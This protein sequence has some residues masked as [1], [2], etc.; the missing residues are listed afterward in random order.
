M[1][2]YRSAQ[3]D[4]KGEASH[5]SPCSSLSRH[6]PPCPDRV[7]AAAQGLGLYAKM[8]SGRILYEEAGLL[9]CEHG[10]GGNAAVPYKLGLL[11]SS[12]L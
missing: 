6:H 5:S 11:Q 1:S 2:H 10:A 4:A 12:W 8:A 9:Y 3:Q 7:L